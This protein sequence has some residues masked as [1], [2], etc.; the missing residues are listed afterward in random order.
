MSARE[1]DA[2]VRSVL[3]AELSR[4]L[5]ILAPHQVEFF[6][7]VY[8]GVATSKDEARLRNAIDLC[9]S[10]HRKNLADPTR[11]QQSPAARAGNKEE[12]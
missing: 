2:L 12:A 9:H 8:P 10:T 6:H 11:M 4:M 7:R 5:S 3:D 1:V